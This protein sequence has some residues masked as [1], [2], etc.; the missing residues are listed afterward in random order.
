MP[1]ADD[2]PG[3]TGTERYD[4]LDAARGIAI[5]MMVIFHTLFDLSWFR[6]WPVNV[7][8][9]FW[10]FFA[11]STA[12][13]F[14]VIAGISL[15]ISHARVVRSVPGISPGEI[16]M[17]YF[18]R[19]A[20]VF[21]CGLLVTL[22]TYLYLGEGF[23]IFGILHVIGVSIMISPLFFRFQEKNLLIGAGV[24]ITGMA[25]SASAI[26]GPDLLLPLGIHSASFWS[27]DYEPLFP[28]SGLVLAGIGLGSLVYPDGKRA[29]PVPGFSRPLISPLASSGRHSLVI[30]LVHQP[31]ILLL[32]QAATGVH[33][34]W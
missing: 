24:I 8:T 17:K 22:A 25:I 21:A 10:Q 19:G 32:L 30:Y 31:V 12:S 3:V 26:S 14:L 20:L 34:F 23:V 6:I 27:V 2:Y 33:I 29:F 7:S 5:L 28:W 1:I 9:G 11:Y 4:E 13:L 16:R 15:S 18:R